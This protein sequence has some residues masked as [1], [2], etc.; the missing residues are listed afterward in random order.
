MCCTP[1]AA[2]AA[3]C[4]AHCS[5]VPRMADS[6]V[7]SLHAGRSKYSLMYLRARW[8]AAS[9][10]SSMHS[11]SWAMLSSASASRPA[12]SSYSRILVHAL[13]PLVPVAADEQPRPLARGGLGQH[14]RVAEGDAASLPGDPLPGPE[15]LHQLEVLLKDPS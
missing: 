3:I 13:E 15:L 8:S 4:S 5:G 9:K 2:C 1:A 10:L 11:V 6:A 14:Q 12:A 7:D